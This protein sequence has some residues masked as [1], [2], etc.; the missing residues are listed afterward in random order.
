[1]QHN[2]KKFELVDGTS[3][4][5]V[6]KPAIFTYKVMIELLDGKHHAALTTTSKD[7][8]RRALGEFR[9]YDYVSWLETELTSF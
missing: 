3:F 9:S 7:D 6:K 1:M 4:A 5:I 2:N 8:A